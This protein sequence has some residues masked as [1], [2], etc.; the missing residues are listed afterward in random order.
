MNTAPTKNLGHCVDPAW[1][2]RQMGVGLPAESQRERLE[3]IDLYVGGF[4]SIARPACQHLAGYG[5]RRFRLVDPKPYRPESVAS[6][7]EPQDVGRSKVQ[8]GAE[9][10]AQQ[11]AQVDA[12]V[13]DLCVCPDG[14]LPEN[15]ILLVSADN[16][17]ADIAANRL[18][19]RMRTRLVKVNIEPRYAF[20]SVRCYDFRRNVQI[21]C[22]CQLSDDAYRNQ[23]HPK[24]CD[25]PVA[26]RT[27][28][29]RWLSLAAG[30]VAALTVAQ[31]AGQRTA[32]AW[33]SRQW[34]LSLAD[35][36]SGWSELTPSP[37]CR[38]DHSRHWP[39][40]RRLRQG[41]GELSLEELLCQADASCSAATELRFCQQ[42]TTR[43]ACDGCGKSLP[44]VRWISEVDQPLGSC[45][46]GGRLLP[47]PYWTYRQIHAKRLADVLPL[48][49]ADWGVEPYAVIEIAGP[50]G[51]QAFV[52][53]DGREAPTSDA[54][55]KG[56]IS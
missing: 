6:Q 56:G 48:P 19:A 21:C 13:A 11:G 28:S 23:R 55:T 49:L 42:V 25:Q 1:L 14:L 38:W 20:V 37:R 15:G 44:C 43:A 26:R 36:R 53:G 18:A 46:C 41:P 10:L 4:G 2:A 45:D 33:Y 51:S 30:T 22:E 16:R 40:L 3:T 17:R 50:R 32:G 9:L 35:G 29:P 34:H 52:V 7:C 12:R 8:V 39:N 5:V 24:S 27:A 54:G 47:L 31:L